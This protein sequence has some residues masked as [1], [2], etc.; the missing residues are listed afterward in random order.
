MKNS[1]ITLNI[2]WLNY[3]FFNRYSKWRNSKEIENEI[4]NSPISEELLNFV[5]EV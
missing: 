5:K 1:Y 3:H 4:K 2:N